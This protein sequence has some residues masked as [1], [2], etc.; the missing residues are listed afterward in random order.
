MDAACLKCIR[1]VVYFNAVTN[2]T[3]YLWR[4]FQNCFGEVAAINW[5]HVFHK[6]KRNRIHFYKLFEDPTIVALGSEF[7]NDIVM[8]R[9]RAATSLTEDQYTAFQQQVVDFR[10]KYAA[11]WDD[12]KGGVFFPNLDLAMTLCIEMRKILRQLV[13]KAVSNTSSQILRDLMNILTNNDNDQW[14]RLLQLDAE[15][16]KKIQ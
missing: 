2:K 12:E 10:N 4:F 15:H 3:P 13:V 11:H 5:C 6:T 9:L 14:L 1:A 16:L 7:T 8:T